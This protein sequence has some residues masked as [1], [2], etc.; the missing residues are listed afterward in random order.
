MPQAKPHIDSGI[1]LGQA[2]GPYAAQQTHEAATFSSHAATCLP[3]EEISRGE[4][5][6][7]PPDRSDGAIASQ[8]RKSVEE[9]LDDTDQ[10]RLPGHAETDDIEGLSSPSGPA[11]SSTATTQARSIPIT[12]KIS[13]VVVE[14]LA[15]E[16]LIR[17]QAA[18]VKAALQWFAGHP[19]GET[20][21]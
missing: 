4:P 15:A 11:S 2:T 5:A 21:I 19:P 14:G 3:S 10:T 20:K 1:P 17:R 6:P 13:L 18:A 8:G 12:V 9:A 16:E 7:D